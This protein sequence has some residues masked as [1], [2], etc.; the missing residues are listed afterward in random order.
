MDRVHAVGVE[1]VREAA[2]AADA[3]DE[4]DVLA[5]EAEL[6]QEGLHRGEDDVVAA[7]GAPAHLLV[8][9]EVALGLLAGVVGKVR[10]RAQAADRHPQVGGRHESSSRVVEM[11]SASSTV[12]N[13]RPRTDVCERTSTRYSAR[14]SIA[15]WPRFISGTTTRS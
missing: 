2:R 8:G 5:L 7:A 10:D 3:G 9:G 6:G 11:T 14:S 15:S 1:V 13:G 4:D 12:E